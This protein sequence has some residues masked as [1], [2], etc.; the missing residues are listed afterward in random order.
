MRARAGS[1]GACAFPSRRREWL[2]AAGTSP[3]LQWRDRAGLRPASLFLRAGAATAGIGDC[4]R[5]RQEARTR[6][7]GRPGARA[8]RGA[9]ASAARPLTARAATDYP[10]RNKTSSGARH[11]HNGEAGESPARSRHCEWG[12][13][14]KQPL[15]ER[16]GRRERR[17]RVTS[18]PT[19]QETYPSGEDAMPRGSRPAGAEIARRDLHSKPDLRALRGL[20]REAA[21]AHLSAGAIE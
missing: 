18:R 9:R 7:V 6:R 19:S 20:V 8:S 2:R 17:E 21:R 11:G 16:R 4:E 15:G 13:L 10:A 3:R 12:P 1:L 14:S 5:R